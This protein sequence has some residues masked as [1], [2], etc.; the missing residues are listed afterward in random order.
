MTTIAYR[1][2]VLAAD[3]LATR[4]DIVVE[5]NAPKIRR[6]P[7][8]E[9]AAFSGELERFEPFIEWYL[10]QTKERPTLTGEDEKT[11]RCIILGKDGITE[12]EGKGQSKVTEP[13]S[14][15]GSGYAVALGALAAGATAY[16]AVSIAA[17]HDVYT[18]GKITWMKLEG[19]DA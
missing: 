9:V 10:D 16:E 3:G 12:F 4:G 6:L 8:G 14:A 15:W 11:S 17:E 5:R 18:G 19:E 7:N 13:Y 1:D 2:G